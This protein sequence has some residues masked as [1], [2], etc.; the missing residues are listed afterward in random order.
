ML[1]SCKVVRLLVTLWTAARQVSLP[2]TV[3]QIFSNPCPLSRW[4]Y[5]AILSSVVPFSSCLQSFPALGSFP[6]SQLL[7]QVAK[8]WE[9]QHLSFQWIFRVD[10]LYDWLVW[11]PCC[12]KDSQESSP[13]PQFKSINLSV[14]SFLYG[15]SHPYVTTGKIVALTILTFVI[16]VIA[17]VFC[18]CGPWL[19]PWSGN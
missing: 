3:S 2:F 18:C 9:L 12:P 10:F 8:V 5:P 17:L 11:S 7:H 4:C 16:K 19:N 15:P 14:L 1:F 6:M 13:A